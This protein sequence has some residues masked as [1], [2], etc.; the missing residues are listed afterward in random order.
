MRA[1]TFEPITVDHCAACGGIWLDPGELAAFRSTHA[2]R[3][4]ASA[5]AWHPLS[6]SESDER[7][8][9]P[10]CAT[11]SLVPGT[12]RDRE[13]SECAS[14]RGLY[15]PHPDRWRRS[16]GTETSG[17]GAGTMLRDVVKAV[18]DFLSELYDT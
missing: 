13:A 5:P 8:A 18:F 4:H 11:A 7:R 12:M 14:C 2:E 17:G 10:R 15:I 16:G 9:C 6:A 3:G 1:E